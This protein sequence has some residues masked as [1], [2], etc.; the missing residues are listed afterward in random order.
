MKQYVVALI[1]GAVCTVVPL[2][3]LAHL[4]RC[5]EKILRSHP[6]FDVANLDPNALKMTLVTVST[7][8][9]ALVML[10]SILLIALSGLRQLKKGAAASQSLPA[11]GSEDKSEEP[12]F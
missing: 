12:Q 4:N 8:A 10:V 9:G 5:L 3:Y 6:D 1:T 7:F 2:C 11:S